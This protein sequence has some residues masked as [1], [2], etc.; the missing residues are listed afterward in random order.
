MPRDPEEAFTGAEQRGQVVE[1]SLPAGLVQLVSVAEGERQR[2]E[3]GVVGLD[4]GGGRLEEVSCV[5]KMVE[6]GGRED[7]ALLLGTQVAN[8]EGREVPSLAAVPL[9]KAEVLPVATIDGIH[10]PRCLGQAAEGGR[11]PSTAPG[12]ISEWPR[13]GPVPASFRPVSPEW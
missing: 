10:R 8:K 6:G 1:Q 5:G 12:R 13:K 11:V 2:G 3:V 4:G 7:D 9:S